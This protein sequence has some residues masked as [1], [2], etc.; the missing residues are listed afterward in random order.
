MDDKVTDTRGVSSG[1]SALS[2]NIAYVEMPIPYS[3]QIQFPA[4]F[5][6]PMSVYLEIGAPHRTYVINDINDPLPVA[7]FEWLKNDRRHDKWFE[8]G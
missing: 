4:K 5:M 7:V 8:V 2:P 1:E 6:L 3:E